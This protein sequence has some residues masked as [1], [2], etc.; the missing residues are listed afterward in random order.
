ML[1]SSR[2]QLMVASIEV[3]ITKS[4]IMVEI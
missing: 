2:H 4:N 3:A 1:E